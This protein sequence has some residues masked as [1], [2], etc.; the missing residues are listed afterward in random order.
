M[1]NK[2]IVIN[3]SDQILRSY[4]DSNDL[5]DTCFNYLLD[6]NSGLINS[7]GHRISLLELANSVYKVLGVNEKL[8][9]NYVPKNSD[10]NYYSPD[11][12]LNYIAIDYGI[13]FQ[14][15]DKQIKNTILAINS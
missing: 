15:I 6:G 14:D 5:L 13:S 7:G 11:S 4:I 12:D 9:Q 2:K 8:T 3:S 10:E 1:K